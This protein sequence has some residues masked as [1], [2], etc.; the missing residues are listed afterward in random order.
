M[1]LDIGTDCV[2]TG[3]FTTLGK[4]GINDVILLATKR[5]LFVVPFKSLQ[6]ESYRRNVTSSFSLEGLDPREALPA[7]LKQDEATVEN[8]EAYLL[9]ALADTEGQ[10]VDLT[11]TDAFKISLGGGLLGWL[12][13]GLYYKPAGARGWSAVT[14]IKKRDLAPLHEFYADQLNPDGKNPYAAPGD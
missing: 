7:L 5:Y 2:L 6:F 1:S 13:K 4:S 3:T 8:I 12:K 9:D 14:G 10:I 11:K